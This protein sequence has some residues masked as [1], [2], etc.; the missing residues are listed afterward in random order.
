MDGS[1]EMRQLVATL[2]NHKMLV[3]SFCWWSV[4]HFQ[5]G[6]LPPLNVTDRIVVG[7]HDYTCKAVFESLFHGTPNDIHVA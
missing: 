5:K 4:R 6:V 3:S 1:I 2:M 7:N